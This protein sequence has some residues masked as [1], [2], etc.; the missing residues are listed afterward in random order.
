MGALSGYLF[1]R[2]LVFVL[3]LVPFSIIYGLSNGIYFIV[4]RVLGYRRKVVAANLQRAFPQKSDAERLKIERDFYH[5]LSDII[6]ESIKGFSMSEATFKKHFSI[7]GDYSIFEKLHKEKQSVVGMCGHYNNW[8]WGGTVAPLYLPQNAIIL[9]APIKN[10]YMDAYVQRKRS[11]LSTKLVS[12]RDTKACFEA[13]H[14]KSTIFLLAGD[15][16]PSNVER[17]H[18]VD[19]LGVDTACLYGGAT[20]AKKY[21]LPMVFLDIEKVKRGYY[22]ASCTVITETPENHTAE[23][24]TA[25]YMEKVEER[26]L[27]QPAF[28]LWSHRRWKHERKKN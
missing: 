4:Y 10:K 12:V 24:L 22:K 14:K 7:E 15:Q 20:Y 3:S 26:I 18:W 27:K 28:W 5:H 23:Q 21:K 13:N 16:N 25:M 1:F 6:V 8:E 9:Y 17:A 2:T 19:F 11:K